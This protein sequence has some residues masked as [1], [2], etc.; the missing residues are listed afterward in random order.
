MI[1]RARF[2]EFNSA[3]E[4]STGDQ[5]A[6]NG[7]VT[8]TAGTD[9]SVTHAEIINGSLTDQGA[10]AGFSDSSNRA[11]F[12]QVA[13]TTRS[14]NLATARTLL[15]VHLRSQVVR[16]SLSPWVLI[17]LLQRTKPAA[18]RA[19]FLSC[20]RFRTVQITFQK[21]DLRTL[22]QQAGVLRKLI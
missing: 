7:V 12:I 6:T 8:F 16:T 18:R 19:F 4:P 5:S 22:M 9:G 1:Y 14:F 11:L 10:I 17:F 2:D 3:S 15:L 21:S 20:C 13:P